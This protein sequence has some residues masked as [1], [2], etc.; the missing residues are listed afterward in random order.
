[1][2][3]KHSNT[4][5]TDWLDGKNA[6]H[7]ARLIVTYWAAKGYT[8]NAGAYPEYGRRRDGTEGALVGYAVRS[9]M[10]GGLPRDWKRPNA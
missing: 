2:A 8:V 4:S 9:D 10:I 6:H 5:D 3:G 7:L 1:M